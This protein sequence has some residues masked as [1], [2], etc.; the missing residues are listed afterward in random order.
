L[1]EGIT[2]RLT[3]LEIDMSGAITVIGKVPT[4]VR[5]RA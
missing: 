1:I 2:D 3:A 4:V 5:S